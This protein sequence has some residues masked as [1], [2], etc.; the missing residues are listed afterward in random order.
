MR[1]FLIL[2]VLATV[3][4]TFA[5][6]PACGAPQVGVDEAALVTP[7]PTCTYVDRAYPHAVTAS[8]PQGRLLI[9]AS[10]IFSKNG[11]DWFEDTTILLHGSVSSGTFQVYAAYPVSGGCRFYP[12]RG[13]TAVDVQTV[14]SE[15]PNLSVPD[16]GVNAHT[17]TAKDGTIYT[18]P[19]RD[20]DSR[21]L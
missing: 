21:S 15:A 10:T 11:V 2:A 1:A 3:V 9:A 6:L 14:K 19:S 20:I 17:F 18:S 13:F 8:D 12:G 16:I 7:D 4:L 5:F